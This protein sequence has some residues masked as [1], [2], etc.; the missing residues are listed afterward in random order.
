M[1]KPDRL[2][3]DAAPDA[4]RARHHSA[5]RCQDSRKVVAALRIDEVKR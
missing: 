4:L 5:R 1:M 2:F 3:G